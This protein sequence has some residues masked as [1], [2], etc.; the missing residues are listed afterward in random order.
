MQQCQVS[1]RYL[2]HDHLPLGEI[3][4]MDNKHIADAIDPAK[5]FESVLFWRLCSPNHKSYALQIH[6]LNRQMIQN[7]CHLCELLKTRFNS[8]LVR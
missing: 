6:F 1:N 2:H 3:Q 7:K 5:A 8:S 4:T